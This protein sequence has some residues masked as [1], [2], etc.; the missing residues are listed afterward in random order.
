MQLSNELVVSKTRSMAHNPLRR[1]PQR[2]G[3]GR[4]GGLLALVATLVVG[5]GP[6]TDRLR[7]QGEAKLDG[8]PINRGSIRFEPNDGSGSPSV[9]A[10][11]RDGE[12]DVPRER[13]L[14]PGVY[15]LSISSPD[16]DGPKVPYVPGPGYPPI[17]VARDRI[18]VSY[19]L[20]S[21]H[22][23]TLDP[24]SDNYFRFDIASNE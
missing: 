18:P 24:S 14:P 16:R 4:F 9:G 19:N 10:M 3:G 11:I 17:M 2:R 1:N 21:E 22:T 12:F 6:T 13:G 23:I 15:R 8:E 5:C 7:I 20:E